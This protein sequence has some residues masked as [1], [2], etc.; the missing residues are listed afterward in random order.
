[1]M[2]CLCKVATPEPEW[3]PAPPVNRARAPP[4]GFHAPSLS[5]QQTPYN[6]M[7][8]H[9]LNRMLSGGVD[10]LFNRSQSQLP[11]R[12]GMPAPGFGLNHSNH[13]D[14]LFNQLGKQNSVQDPNIM[15]FDHKQPLHSSLGDGFGNKDW[16]VKILCRCYYL[17]IF[18]H[19]LISNTDDLSICILKL[20]HHFHLS[21][22]RMLDSL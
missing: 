14:L 2:F 10:S 17:H 12:A 4:P 15:L 9:S 22:S 7:S 5:Q 19:S 21:K 6:F 3:P 16:Q 11:A 8:D 13:H 18:E 20:L 1:M